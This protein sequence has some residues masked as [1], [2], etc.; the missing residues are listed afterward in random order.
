MAEEINLLRQLVDLA[1]AKK[2]ALFEDNLEAL[3]GIVAEEEKTLAVVDCLQ[4]AAYAEARES[5]EF[6][7]FIQ[8]KAALITR[9]KEINLLNQRLLEDALAVVEY[10]LKLIRGEEENNL[11]GSSGKVKAGGNRSV[12]NWRG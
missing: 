10:S 6:Q 4:L 2:E 8:E 1:T 3:R 7:G 9:L 12:F 11:Y 5:A